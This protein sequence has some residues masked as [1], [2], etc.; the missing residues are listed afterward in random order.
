LAGAALLLVAGGAAQSNGSTSAARP[1]PIMELR[2]Y[3]LMP[4]KRDVLVELFEREFIEGQEATGMAILGQFHDLDR[5]DRFV[6]IRAF[7][8]MATRAVSLQA[9]YDGP[10]WKAHRT[11]AN[12]TMI[13]SD[14]VLLLRPAAANFSF[15]VDP[16]TRAPRGA[17]ALPSTVVMAGIHPTQRISEAALLEFFERRL[18]PVLE[19]AGGRVLGLFV[20]DPAPNNYPRLPLRDGAHVVAWF[21]S[22]ATDA[23]QA[24]LVAQPDWQRMMSELAG[25]VEGTPELLR[26]RPT[27]RSL[28]G[29]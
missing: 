5:P 27:P 28:L 9:F 10:V 8:D 25:L 2:Q 26:L 3:T 24:A 19:Q 6:W 12:G 23:E 29:R 16:R 4:G 20:T 7:P 15:V 21:A 13:D 11:V 18:R 1:L 22:F 17:T 14:N